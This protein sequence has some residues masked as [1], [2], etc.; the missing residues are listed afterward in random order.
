M[1]KSL[2]TPSILGKNIK[3]PLTL[4]D[5]ECPVCQDVFIEP[6]TLPCKHRFCFQ[7]FDGTMENVSLQCPM[8]RTRVGGWLR[9]ATKDNRVIDVKLWELIKCEFSEYVEAKLRGETKEI[10]SDLPRICVS[11]P[12]E[13]RKEYELHKKAIEEEQR[14]KREE[15]ERASADLIRKLQEEE[16]EELTKKTVKIMKVLELDEELAR[17]MML[18]EMNR[19]KVTSP[20]GSTKKTVQMSLDSKASSNQPKRTEN[21]E[22]KALKSSTSTMKGPMDIFL[23]KKK[24]S[25]NTMKP[26]AFG[27]TDNVKGFLKHDLLAEGEKGRSLSS[28]STGSCDSINQEMHHFKPIKVAPRTPPKKMPDGRVIE[29]KLVKI[30]PVHLSPG[31]DDKSGRISLQKCLG[32]GELNLVSATDAAQ[33]SPRSNVVRELFPPVISPNEPR[34]PSAFCGTGA[35]E[36]DRGSE[37][38][39]DSSGPVEPKVPKKDAGHVSIEASAEEEM[40][41]DE[42][43]HPLRKRKR[44]RQTCVAEISGQSTSEM[45]S[46]SLPLDHMRGMGEGHS[47]QYDPLVIASDIG[48]SRTGVSEAFLQQQFLMEAKLRQ[49]RED[50]EL[51]QRL[52]REW[53]GEDRRVDRRKGTSLEYDLRR[54]LPSEVREKQKGRV[55]SRSLPSKVNKSPLKGPRQRLLGELISRQSKGGK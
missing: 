46:S 29:P 19:Y 1:A 28:L 47:S 24:A 44:K 15:E 10:R 52:Q 43:K 6:V 26:L 54:K 53:E 49:E 31:M 38:K 9:A 30:T 51:A 33:I 22:N 11:Q 12:G 18:D 35:L 55:C 13:V 32:S 42:S 34:G 45:L 4:V 2:K 3:K 5:V 8:C 21:K 16:N 40:E 37:S 7:C 41:E 25:C 39:K 27:S 48:S 36:I 17:K 20:S 23:G 14:R 50:M